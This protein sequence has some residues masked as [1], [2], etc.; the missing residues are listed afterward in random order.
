MF[1]NETKF[2][3]SVLSNYMFSACEANFSLNVDFM[4]KNPK[5]MHKIGHVSVCNFYPIE[6]TKK[7]LHPALCMF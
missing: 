1:F 4:A 5:N 2:I 3:R 6:V 7:V